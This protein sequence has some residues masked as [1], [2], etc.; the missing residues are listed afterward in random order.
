MSNQ[1]NVKFKVV[2]HSVNILCHPLSAF[3]DSECKKARLN[4]MKYQKNCKY[5]I[6]LIIIEMVI[7]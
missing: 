4:R 3:N 5:R 2:P 6:K 7:L 1:L